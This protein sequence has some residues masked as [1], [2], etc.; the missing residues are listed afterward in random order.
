MSGGFAPHV[1]ECS[2]CQGRNNLWSVVNG[3]LLQGVVRCLK[4][5]YAPETHSLLLK[6]PFDLSSV[7]PLPTP[8]L[9]GTYFAKIEK[10]GYISIWMTHPVFTSLKA[11]CSHYA[12]C[13]VGCKHTPSRIFPVQ[14][15]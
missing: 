15:K 5:Y 12:T 7:P 8:L 6:G 4:E 11:V 9:G 1:W 10:I 2:C 14:R 13:D 3:L